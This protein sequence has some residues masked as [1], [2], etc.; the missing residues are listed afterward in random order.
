VTAVEGDSCLLENI[1]IDTRAI[2]RANPGDEI[3]YQV[4]IAIGEPPGSK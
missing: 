4:I 3:D 2:L 1:S